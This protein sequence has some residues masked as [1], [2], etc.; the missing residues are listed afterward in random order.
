MAGELLHVRS[1]RIG[2]LDAQAMQAARV[3]QANLTKPA[4]ALGRL[5]D[6]EHSACRHHR[7]TAAGVDPTP[8]DRVCGRPWRDRGRC[9]CL[10]VRSDGADGAQ[11][12]ARRRRHQ[13]AGAPVWGGRARAGRRRAVRPADTRATAVSQGAPRYGQSAPR[14]GHAAREAIAAVEAGI[15]AAQ[16]AIAAG[17][18]V[19]ATGDMGIGNTTASAAIAAVMT[20][21]PVAEVT[22]F[23]TGLDDDGPPP[24]SSRDRRGT[25]AASPRPRAMPST[26]WPR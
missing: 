1:L 23:G 9:Q 19:L 18:R 13:R 11:L 15:G 6:S 5:E 21:K 17:A 12:P 14:A 24:Q 22:G 7:P 20:G 2:V 4:G 16:A 3:R 25:G 8:G 10:S 26:Y